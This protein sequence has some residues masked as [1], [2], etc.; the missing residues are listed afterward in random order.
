M[1][2]DRVQ[3]REQREYMGGRIEMWVQI[4]AATRWEEDPMGVTG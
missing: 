3:E 4:R 1:I 2:L